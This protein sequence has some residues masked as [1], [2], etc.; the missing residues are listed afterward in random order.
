MTLRF[1][2]R[3]YY[4]VWPRWLWSRTSTLEPLRYFQSV[5]LP[6]SGRNDVCA[7]LLRP[8]RSYTRRHRRIIGGQPSGIVLNVDTLRSPGIA[9]VRNSIQGNMVCNQP[10]N[11]IEIYN[12]VGN[13]VYNNWIGRNSAGRA[14]CKWP[15][16]RVSAGL[17]LQY[18]RWK[19]LGK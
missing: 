5:R 11:G 12:G 6:R 17:Q 18:R 4:R 9:S 15:L 1:E 8:R 3:S 2:Q 13:G 19:R 10:A 7:L 16:G 14:I